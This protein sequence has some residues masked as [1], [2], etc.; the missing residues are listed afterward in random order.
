[1]AT[2][3]PKISRRRFLKLAGATGA[4]AVP[5]LLGYGLLREA[6]GEAPPSVSPYARIDVMKN[7]PL[8]PAAASPILVLINERADNPFGLYLAEILRAEGLNCFQIAHTS[9]FGNAPL[10]WYDLILL[11]E[12]PLGSDQVQLLEGYVSRG[13]RLVAMRPDARL[14]SL[15]GVERVAGSTAEG[16]VQVEASHPIGRGIA[17]EALQFHGTAGH[18]RLAGAR[19]VAWLLGDANTPTGFPALTVHRHRRGQAALWAFDL[20]RSVAYTRQGNPAWANRERDGLKGVRA[21]DMFEG[22]VDL[23]RLGIPQADEQQRLLANLLSVLSQDARPLP[24]LWYFPG[25]AQTVFIPTGDSHGNPA[26]AIEDVL[27]RVEE[28]GGHMSIYYTA[29]PTGDLRRAAKKALLPMARL[30]FVRGILAGR[31]TSPTPAQV[32]DWRERGHEFGLHPYVEDGLD[33][34]WRRYWQEFT[35]VGY[36]P[37]SPTTRTHRVLWEGWVETARAQAAYGIRLNL[38]HYHLGPAFR[39][40]AGEWPCGYFTGS[41]MTMKFIDEQGH[42]LNIYQQLTQLADEHLLAMPWVTGEVS[43]LTAEE[44]IEVSRALL[45]RSLD[46][47]YGAITAQ[48]HVDPF[49]FGGQVASEE[50]HWLEGTLDYAA[51]QGIPI[52]SAL[53]WLRFIEVRHDANLVDIQWHSA[54]HRLSFDLVAQSAPDLALTV[55]VPQHHGN[56]GLAQVEVDGVPVEHRV[57]ELGSGKYGWV[58]TPAGFHQVVATFE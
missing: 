18:Y 27:A 34:G 38:D 58:S 3:R 51:A 11:A 4:L 40:E 21:A 28:R 12:G 49:V 48:F 47:A 43:R 25:A 35:G 32:A 7:W 30:P 57:R 6:R 1:M 46:G 10:R 14:S 9:D 39:N 16:Y 42:V 5:T 37:V 52:W 44:A 22:W 41:G 19:V 23:D 45:R 8:R 50:A 29:Y 55:M 15:L 20:A 36:G 33:T 17:T 13:G 56:A 26:S 54:S 2:H 24:R 53:E 31:H